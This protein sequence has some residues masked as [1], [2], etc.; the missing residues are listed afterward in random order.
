MQSDLIF[1]TILIKSTFFLPCHTQVVRH[2]AG[3][4]YQR[5][6]SVWTTL[7]ARW[8][9][10]GGGGFRLTVPVLQREREAVED[11][12]HGAAG[13]NKRQQSCL[14]D[15]APHGVRGGNVCPSQRHQL[16]SPGQHHKH[17]PDAQKFF[18]FFVYLFFF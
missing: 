9:A 4:L 16:H 3:I 7:Q 10:L 1:P 2:H 5:E 15:Q 12:W 13:R 18:G 14:Q 8:R 17:A 6:H 11:G